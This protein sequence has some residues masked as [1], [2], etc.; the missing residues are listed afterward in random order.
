MLWW[1]WWCTRYAIAHAHMWKHMHARIFQ[2]SVRR[3]C[4]HDRQP[5]RV[6]SFA[7]GVCFD[8]IPEADFWFSSGSSRCWWCDVCCQAAAWFLPAKYC[9]MRTNCEKEWKPKTNVFWAYLFCIGIRI[10]R[11]NIPAKHFSF[12]SWYSPAEFHNC[13]LRVWYVLSSSDYRIEYAQCALCMW[14]AWNRCGVWTRCA[15]TSA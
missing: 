7:F 3:A 1:R 12:N 14:K 4:S 8:A 9:C 13:G 11:K 5:L 6:S 2:V 10:R 15:A